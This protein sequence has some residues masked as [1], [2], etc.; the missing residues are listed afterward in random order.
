MKTYSIPREYPIPAALNTAEEAVIAVRGYSCCYDGSF[1]GSWRLENRELNETLD[2]C[3]I[4]QAGVELDLGSVSLRRD[5]ST[6]GPGN[7]NTPSILFDGM[8]RPLV[9]YALG[10]VIWYQ[11]ESNA[12]TIQ[13]SKDYKDVLKYMIN[14][15]RYHFQE[16]ELPFIQVQL[17]NY[18]MPGQ[19]NDKATWA[20]LRESQRRLCEE[21]PGV[22]M[23]TAIDIGDEIDVHPQ[24]KQSVGFRLAASAL[25]KFCGFSSITPNGPELLRAVNE[26]SGVVRLD[27]AWADGLRIDDEAAQCF[28]V[29]S[30]GEN[31]TAAQKA[32]VQ[33]ASVLLHSGETAKIKAVRYA[34]S[35]NPVCTLYNSDGFPASPFH[36]D[37]F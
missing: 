11:G 35:E 13:D 18:G 33:G 30:D 16:P 31:F 34:W 8:I 10:G 25:N 26:T 2:I 9:P 5:T 28:Y 12:T 1:G 19:Y 32:E 36:I 27:F 4:W 29:S 24:D 20:Y 14:D 7:P 23:A 17:A 22:S 15:W 21:L 37:L 6:F 3:G